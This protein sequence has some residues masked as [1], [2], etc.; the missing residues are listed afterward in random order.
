METE[1]LIIGGGVTGTGIARDLSLRGINNILVEKGDI[2]AGASGG[3]HGL[4]HSGARYVSNDMESARQCM[5]EGLILR[6]TAPMCIDDCQGLFVAVKGDDEKYADLFPGLCKKAGIF[7]KA[8]SPDE[9]RNSEPELSEDIIA[10]YKVKDGAIDPFMLSLENIAQAKALGTRL[11]CHT[12]LVN[13]IMGSH[14]IE[15]VICKDTCSGKTMHV[16]PQLVINAAGA[17]AGT[18]AAMAGASLNI[19]HSMGTLLVTQSR[20]TRGVVNRLRPPSDADIVVPGGMVSIVGTTSIRVDDPDYIFPTIEETDHIV[21]QAAQMLPCLEST[22]YIRAYSGVRP[23][24]GMADS[25]KNNQNDRNVSRGFMLIDH[26]NAGI[27]NFITITGGKLT[28]F[29]LMAEKTSDMTCLKLGNKT[30]CTTKTEPLPSTMEGKWTEPGLA[31]RR[32]A[33]RGHGETD[34][35]LCE[36]E[37]ISERTIE[38]IADELKKNNEIP[39]LLNI[40]KR[41]RLGKGPCQGTFC[42]IRVL[43]HMYDKGELTGAHGL[44][45]IKAFLNERWKGQRPILWGEQLAQAELAEAM[46]C[47]FFDLELAQQ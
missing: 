14:G 6:K 32:W 17:W 9:A 22:R 5:E 43:A 21:E 7:C 47:G 35:I 42:S 27:D 29:R 40:G 16:Q 1:V 19:L 25:G 37:M 34:K 46:H 12:R 38:D 8:L 26:E 15:T 3:N 31:P 45:D 18:V 24:V 13:F 28:T 33:V 20:I 4:L 2:N 30:K 11:F 39:D 10:A 36:C 23:L 41:S 44:D